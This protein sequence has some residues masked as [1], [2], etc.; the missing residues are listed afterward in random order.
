ASGGELRKPI[1][2]SRILDKDGK[3]LD[4]FSS[5]SKRVLSGETAHDLTDMLR[6]VTSQ[7]TGRAIRAYL[8][9]RPDLAGKTG[10]TQNNTDGWFI[11]MHP[12]MVAGAWVGFNDSRVTMRSDYWGQGGHNAL[13]LVGDFFRQTLKGKLIQVKAKFPQPKRPPPLI[14]NAPPEGDPHLDTVP[15]GYGVIQRRGSNSAV[16]VGPDGIQAGERHGNDERVVSGDELGRFLSDLG[17]DPSTGLR[18]DRGSGSPAGAGNAQSGGGTGPH[19]QS[20][21]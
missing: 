2:V 13:L 16:V 17:R 7:G 10:T 14:V 3:V 15:P 9:S 8:G 12:R 6:A 5:D 4:T 20:G 19:S 18:V 1:L 11:L 21:H